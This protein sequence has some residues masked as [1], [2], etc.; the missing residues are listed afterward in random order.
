MHNGITGD[1]P[2]LNGVISATENQVSVQYNIITY[3]TV[4]RSSTVIIQEGKLFVHRAGADAGQKF[5]PQPSCL[6]FGHPWWSVGLL[7]AGAPCRTRLIR[8]SGRQTP[9][10]NI[11]SAAQAT[12]ILPVSTLQF[13]T[14]HLGFNGRLVHLAQAPLCGSMSP[15]WDAPATNVEVFRPC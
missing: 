5:L 4:L 12:D 9:L 11:R 6:N 3:T 2:I 14:Q 7:G 8:Y 10:Y 15:K 13:P 1:G